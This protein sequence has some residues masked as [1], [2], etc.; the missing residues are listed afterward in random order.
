MSHT[1]EFFWTIAGRFATLTAH[2]TR[3]RTAMA[4]N[5]EGEE[6]EALVRSLE[7]QEQRIEA[8]RLLREYHGETQKIIRLTGELNQQGKTLTESEIREIKKGIADCEERR[9]TLMGRMEQEYHAQTPRQL[10]I[11]LKQQGIGST[12]SNHGDIAGLTQQKQNQFQGANQQGAGS[13]GQST[14]LEKGT[15][16]LEGIQE[17]MQHFKK[18]MDEAEKA[19]K[20]Y[21]SMQEE[22]EKAF[23]IM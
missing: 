7:T 4:A 12:G 22:Y 2:R 3:E 21:Q 11:V 13:E 10:D 15:A 1:T 23:A 6:G 19:K 20:N 9:V 18:A 16:A 14:S 5:L 8:A 17:S